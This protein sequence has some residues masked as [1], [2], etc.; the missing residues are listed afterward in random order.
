MV[1]RGLQNDNDD[2]DRELTED[3]FEDDIDEGSDEDGGDDSDDDDEENADGRDLEKGVSKK[4]PLQSRWA[5]LRTAVLIGGASLVKDKKKKVYSPT[6]LLYRMLFLIHYL[7]SVG[8]ACE[9]G[10]EGGERE[11]SALRKYAWSLLQAKRER[12]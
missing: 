11:D 7:L 5:K 8:R 4:K 10:A 9:A 1:G 12:D 3:Y 6:C 2:D